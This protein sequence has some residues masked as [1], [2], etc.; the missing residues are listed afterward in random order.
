M[1]VVV[2]VALL[3]GAGRLARSVGLG[4]TGAT[5]VTIARWP[6]LAVLI[7]IGLGVLYRR[8]PDRP[9]VEWRWF[10]WGAGVAAAL[11][12]CASAGFALYASVAGKFSE[13]YGAIA[14]VVVMMMWLFLSALAILI[15]GEV[16]A[17][18]ARSKRDQPV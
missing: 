1:T 10:S 14:A 5:V 3:A 7:L 8:G 18:L 6:M 2:S 11:W 9:R 4:A 16:D 12:M 17:E 13:S 15:G